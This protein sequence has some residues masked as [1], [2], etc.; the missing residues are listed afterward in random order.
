MP[1][2]TLKAIRY[3]RTD[4]PTLNIEKLR[5][6]KTNSTRIVK[7]VVG[8]GDVLLKLLKIH[9][10][11]IAKNEKIKNKV[12]CRKNKNNKKYY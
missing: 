3:V 6:L 8:L 9:F 5:F 11:T 1:K 4:G 2:I 7:R 12:L 10:S